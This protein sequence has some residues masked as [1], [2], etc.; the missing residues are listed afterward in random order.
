M[1]ITPFSLD[2]YVVI[3]DQTKWMFV[4]GYQWLCNWEFR[5]VTSSQRVSVFQGFVS[6]TWHD[7]VITVEL[8]SK[9]DTK[10]SSLLKTVS[11]G[12]F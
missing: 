3:M 4:L 2:V 6:M 7:S 1:S 9:T 8:G 11:A 10:T 12:G 5:G